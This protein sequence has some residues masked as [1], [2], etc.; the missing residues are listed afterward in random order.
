MKRLDAQR[1]IQLFTKVFTKYFLN[2]LLVSLTF[3]SLIAASYQLAKQM[4][5]DKNLAK[6][7]EGVTSLSYQIDRIEEIGNIL[8]GQKEYMRLMLLQGAPRTQN[9]YDIGIVQKT[10]ARLCAAQQY[11]REG[12]IIF[13]YNPILIANRFSSDS[14]LNILPGS[15]QQPSFD[16]AWHDGMFSE[17][18]S[19]RLSRHTDATGRQLGILCTLNNTYHDNLSHLS[20]ISF[21]LD[22]DAV[23]D[24]LLYENQWGDSF[25][26]IQNARGEIVFSFNYESGEPLAA[27]TGKATI[28]QTDYL[29]LESES[30][31]GFV[32]VSGVSTPYLQRNVATLI[33]LTVFYGV[34]AFVLIV[35]FALVISVRETFTFR[36]MVN[37]AS[38][39][40]S[41]P[42][43]EAASLTMDHVVHRIDDM[44]AEQMGKIE[45]L[46]KAIKLC[47]LENLLLEGVAS[48][49]E[50]AE[51]TQYYDNDFDFFCVAVFRFYYD[52]SE[53]MG[54]NVQHGVML[55]I[56]SVLM[57]TLNR[58]YLSLNLSASD[59]CF[60][61]FFDGSDNCSIDSL[62]EELLDIVRG[63]NDSSDLTPIIH[64]GLSRITSGIKN[65]RGA[66]LQAI[67]ALTVNTLPGRNDAY[68]YSTPHS[69]TNRKM[70]DIAMLTKCYNTILRGEAA[71]LEE[72]FEELAQKTRQAFRYEEDKLQYYFSLRQPIYNAYLEIAADSTKYPDVSLPRYSDA[73]SVDDLIRR[74]RQFALRLCDISNSIKKCN[75]DRLKTDI[76]S[77]IAGNFQDVNLSAASIAQ[78][79]GISEKYVFSVVK[80]VTGKNLGRMIE[81]CRIEEAE[82]LLLSTELTNSSIAQHCGFGSDNT[83]YRA[84]AKCH[85]VTPSAWKKEQKTR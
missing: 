11:V 62:R 30:A 80:D 24:S 15:L 77:Y 34:A 1:F 21:L 12:F 44:N 69:I 43:G 25:A 49:R 54:Q 19:L 45:Q 26:Y 59:L 66:Y 29:V 73:E 60:V 83:F 64:I 7:N 82:R 32:A 72:L 70:F 20:L 71:L 75:N 74:L 14:Y 42:K 61:I 67:D 39:Y 40:T 27:G 79:F 65:T 68:I 17:K 41:A 22:Y 56:E 2:M 48:K 58:D 50:E 6:L 35:L 9:Y 47:T 38:W 84:F 5:L 52:D 55:H 16:K 51:I 36:R 31:N 63:V 8:L 23:R 78:Q 37:I 28:G 18:F 81:D 4:T 33:R 10:F 53:P 57:K 85:H 76:L 3:I 46:N 13:Q